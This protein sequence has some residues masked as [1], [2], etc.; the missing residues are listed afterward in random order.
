MG[1]INRCNIAT[2]QL[3]FWAYCAVMGMSLSNI[4]LLYSGASIVRVFLITA[5]TFGSMSLYGYSTKRDLTKIGSFL[6]MGLIG[7]IIASI[8]NIFMKSAG[9]YYAL[10]YISVV[11]FIG[12]TAFDLQK[13]KSLYYQLNE[14]DSRS[15]AAIS[16]ALNLYLDFINL[17]LSLLRII[18]DRR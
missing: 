15:R 10:S 7:I 9:L 13:L 8:V 2:L 18:G 12:L 1:M 16:G 4:F 17:F 11:V 5:A 6:Y 14:D 3:M